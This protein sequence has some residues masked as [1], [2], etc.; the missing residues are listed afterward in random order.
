[1]ARLAV[2][3]RLAGRSEVLVDGVVR[4]SGAAAIDGLAWSPDGNW[5]LLSLPEADQWVFVRAR[6]PYGLRAVANV[7]SQFRSRGFPAVRG[8]CCF[9]RN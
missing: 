7:S 5:L 1:M 2:V 8:W 6:G 9:A 4:F 3:R